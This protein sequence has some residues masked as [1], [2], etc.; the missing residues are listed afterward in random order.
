MSDPRHILAA[1][2]FSPA[3]E[4]AVDTAIELAVRFDA[5]L[6]VLHVLEPVRPDAVAVPVP[7][8]VEVLNE[9]RSEAIRQLDAAVALARKQRSEARGELAEGTAWREIVASAER[10]RADLVVVGSHGRRGLSHHLLGSVAER[11][12]RA[13]PVAVLTVHGFW[14]EDRVQAGR[15]LA[16]AIDPAR[17]RLPSVVAISRGGMIVGAELA[18]A[19]G[20]PLDVLL[21][22]RLEMRGML[23]GAMCESGTTRLAPGAAQSAIGAE[24]R[25]RLFSGT[26]ETLQE[27]GAKIR[28]N[29]WLGEL[30]HRTVILVSDSFMEPWRA[31]AAADVVVKASPKSIVMAAPVATEQALGALKEQYT[32]VIT[33]H[34]LHTRADPS[35]AYRNFRR[36]SERSLAQLFLESRKALARSA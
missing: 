6:S 17:L 32:D 9:I 15:E 25:E 36:P 24:Q 10:L 8:P 16:A 4:R 23:L 11:V 22:G 35:A 3:S 30:W 28:G 27:D 1:T 13:S 12:V 31:L 21:T 29:A 34:T 20:V 7:F 33:L 14:F 18:R 26:R 5:K 2:D 19:L